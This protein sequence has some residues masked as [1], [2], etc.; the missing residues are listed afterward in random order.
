MRYQEGITRFLA[1]E[2]GKQLRALPPNDGARAE[3]VSTRECQPKRLCGLCPATK[4]VSE[5]QDFFGCND[6]GLCRFPLRL[7]RQARR[8]EPGRDLLKLLFGSRGIF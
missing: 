2:Y 6:F 5:P 7:H 8:G 3:G 1:W 4:Y